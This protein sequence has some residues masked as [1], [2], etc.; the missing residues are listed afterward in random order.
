MTTMN[1][2]EAAES[3]ALEALSFLTRDAERIAGFL[4]NAGIGPDRLRDVA[5]E[6]G[7][8]AAVLDYLLADEPMLLIFSQDSGIAAR[9][10][11]AARMALGDPERP[12]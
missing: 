6:P 11:P 3:V 9:S 10:I 8:L 12:F 1:S 2:R 7:F 4:A 5:G